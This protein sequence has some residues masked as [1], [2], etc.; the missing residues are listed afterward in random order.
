MSFLTKMGIFSPIFGIQLHVLLS[1][2]GDLLAYFWKPTSCEL[3]SG[4]THEYNQKMKQ[5][6]MSPLNAFSL[7]S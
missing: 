1:Q 7:Q 6:H 3:F 4:H 2:N 5:A